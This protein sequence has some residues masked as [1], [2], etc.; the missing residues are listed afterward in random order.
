[1]DKFVICITKA[2]PAADNEVLDA[3]LPPVKQSSLALIRT[4]GQILFGVSKVTGPH[5]W[6]RSAVGWVLGITVFSL[7]VKTFV[8]RC[9]DRSLTRYKEMGVSVA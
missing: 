9:I 1:M 3:D 7:Y 8:E 5:C 4:W 6:F 2:P